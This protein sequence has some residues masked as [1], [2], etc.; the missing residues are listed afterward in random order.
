MA[1]IITVANQK[2]GVSKTTTSHAMATGLMLKGFKTLLI[3][4]DPQ[5]NA[6]YTMGVDGKKASIYEIIKGIVSP[7]EAVQTTEQGDIIPSNLNLAGADMEFKETGREFLLKDI[8]DLLD[9]HYDYIIIDTPPTLGILTINALTASNEVIIPVGADIYSLQGL[10]QLNETIGKVRKYCNKDIKIA[11]LLL[12]RYNGR[13]ILSK[14][15]KESIEH[16][17]EQIDTKLYDTI[18]REGI[19]VKEAQT[20]RTTVF[21]TAIKSNPAQDYLSFIDEYLKE[22]E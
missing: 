15:M 17:A 9:S 12:T 11:G 22:A 19:A 10:G 5:G 13:S 3:D 14:D 20:Q 21:S 16:A 2:G 6:T 7:E 18:I 4:L 8:V 1:K